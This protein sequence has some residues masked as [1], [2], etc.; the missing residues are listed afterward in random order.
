MLRMLLIAFVHS[1]WSGVGADLNVDP[2]SYNLS[3]LTRLGG[4][5]AEN[6]YDGFVGIDFMVKNST[7]KITIFASDLNLFTQKTWLL[8]KITGRRISVAK[9]T[10][11]KKSPIPDELNIYFTHTLWLG[12]VYTLNMNFQGALNRPQRIGYFSVR[13]NSP[14]SQFYA[15]THMEPVYARYVFPCF[16]QPHLRTKLHLRMIHNKQYVALSNM[17]VAEKKS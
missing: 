10:R 1:H 7:K 17:P 5:S 13:Y 6:R 3:I 14:V 16:D 12:E 4:G 8:R 2:I 11:N 9:V 15:L